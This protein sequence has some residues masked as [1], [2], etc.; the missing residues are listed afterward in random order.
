VLYDQ[1]E[2]V[3][4]VIERC[5]DV[6]YAVDACTDTDGPSMLVIPEHPLTKP[7][8][9]MAKRGVRIRF[10]TEIT[11]DNLPYCKELM[12]IAE[13]R[14]LDEVKGN[15]GIVD[16]DTY[17][18]SAT[19]TESGPPPQLIISTVK[20][21]VQQQQHFFDMLWH[22]EEH[23]KRQ[24]IDTIQDGVEISDL[25]H[26]LVRSA[27]E[28][29][30][31]LLPTTNTFHRYEREGLMELIK[32]AAMLLGVKIR[33]L[34]YPDNESIR[35]SINQDYTVGDRIRLLMLQKSEFQSKIMTIIVDD[36]YSLAIEIEHDRALD[37]TDAVG[38]ATY[39]N[40]DS[41]V[42]TYVSIF[43]TLWLK[44]ELRSKQKKT[45]NIS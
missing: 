22:I 39:S 33:I 42:A 43:E 26:K 38:L 10:I 44:A 31:I 8:A 2:I 13:V 45:Q 36:E 9:D 37:S 19:N 30:L 27:R 32:N 6:K 23:T 35:E 4:R 40:S 29:M 5:Y 20:V 3:R 24:F 7:Y 15:L 18:A 25:V 17:Y 14:H 34:A 16:G 12:K 1:N 41:T 11:K 21:I 28:E